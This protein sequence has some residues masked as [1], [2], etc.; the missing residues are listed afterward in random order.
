MEGLSC[1][2]SCSSI[3]SLRYKNIQKIYKN[4]Q[5]YFQ[6]KIWWLFSILMSKF[7]LKKETIV[8]IQF[9]EGVSSCGGGGM[10]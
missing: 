1:V 6:A 8:G 10:A 3:C 7:G 4:I 9:Q 2:E 5:K